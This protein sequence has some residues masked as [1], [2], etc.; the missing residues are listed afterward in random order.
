MF[1]Q[2]PVK[3]EASR[4]RIYDMIAREKI[5]LQAFHFPFP[6]TGHIEKLD[7]GYR[8]VPLA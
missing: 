2:D 1:D 3:A 5:L 6:G 8:F 7:D 4:R